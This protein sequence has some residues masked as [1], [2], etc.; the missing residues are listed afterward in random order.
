VPCDPIQLG[1]YVLTK[2]R[3]DIQMVSTDRQVHQSVL[4]RGVSRI[5]TASSHFADAA[6]SA[7]RPSPVCA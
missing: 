3:C 2:R 1:K 6:R 7:G 4:S 5:R